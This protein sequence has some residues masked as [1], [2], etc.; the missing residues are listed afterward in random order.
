M[1]VIGMDVEQTVAVTPS[2]YDGQIDVDPY[3]R[4]PRDQEVVPTQ[5]RILE[6]ATAAHGYCVSG[7]YPAL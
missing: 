3:C 4:L 7:G 2:R 1:L 6:E 5:E